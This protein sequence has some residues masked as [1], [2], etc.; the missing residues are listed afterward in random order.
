MID[1][2]HDPRALVQRV[3]DQAAELGFHLCGIAPA[4]TPAGAHRLVQW[5]QAGYAAEMDYFAKRLEA[6]SDPSRVLAGVRSIIVLGFPYHTVP[7]AAPAAHQGRIARY[8][9]GDADY[10]DLIH[11]RLKRLKQTIEAA[12]PQAQARGVVDTAPLMEREFAQLAGLG[13]TGKNSL[14]LNQQRG[15]Y[16]FLACLLTTLDLPASQPH[17]SAHCGT[18]TRC[19][20]ACPTDAFAAPGVVDSR[21]CI[22]YLTIEH[23]GPIP[24]ELRAGIGNW[25]LGCDVCQEVCPWN[26]RATRREA[27]TATAAELWPRREHNPIDLIE[28]LELD[29]AT[30]R[31]RF[32]STPLWRPRRRGILRNAAI[33]LGNAREPRAAEPLVRLLEDDEPL[34]RGAAAWALGEIGGQQA[35]LQ[36]RL[37]QEPDAEVRQ[38]LQQALRPQ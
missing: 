1:L 13:W 31:K 9:W 14:L 10:H 17:G 36:A 32:R 28:L 29:E 34:V 26:Q 12:H 25:L 7:A 30:F 18:C 23:R 19:L 6:Y 38:E 8:A 33:C 27:A 4:V 16:F 2:L 37:A 22:S 21:R 11:P 20:D 35:A 5:V 24:R 3:S 15:S